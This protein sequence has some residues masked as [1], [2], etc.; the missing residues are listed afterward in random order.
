MVSCLGERLICPWLR[1]ICPTVRRL[2]AAVAASSRPT[3]RC[4]PVQARHDE[5]ALGITPSQVH[6]VEDGA[7]MGKRD[8][9]D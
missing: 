6:E 1:Q 4:N 5:G 3:S 7:P 9:D 2:S 8:H